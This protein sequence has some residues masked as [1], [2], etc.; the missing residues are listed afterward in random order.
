MCSWILSTCVEICTI[1]Y[2]CLAYVPNSDWN[3]YSTMDS[4]YCKVKIIEIK[5]NLQKEWTI[6][7]GKRMK[8][9]KKRPKTENPFV[10][11][12]GWTI[13]READIPYNK[14]TGCFSVSFWNSSA[15]S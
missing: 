5:I 2:F 3:C 10:V 6:S 14:L 15:V 4:S 1:S 8:I 12:L 11:N 7:I 9:N 13:Y